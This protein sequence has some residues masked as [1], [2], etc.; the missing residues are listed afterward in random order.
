MPSVQT[1]SPSTVI[2]DLLDSPQVQRAFQFIDSHLDQIT[3]EQIRICS[4]PAPPFGEQ[5]RAGYLRQRFLEAGLADA[6]LDEEGNCLALR[7]GESPLR[8]VVVSAHL[9]TVFPADTNLRVT[10]GSDLIHGPGLGDNSLG[11]AALLGLFWAFRERGLQ[12]RGDVWLIANVCE[13]G[14]G[15]LR[16]KAV[17][18]TLLGI[19][20]DHAAGHNDPSLRGHTI[21][22]ALRH[23]P[24]RRLEHLRGSTAV[25][26][27]GS[28]QHRKLRAFRRRHGQILDPSLTL[29][30]RPRTSL[31]PAPIV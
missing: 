27:G 19:P 30:P 4:I 24:A 1:F 28:R 17:C 16:D 14:L 5:E 12:P 20:A 3:E 8:H 15:D 11:V 7:E 13:E 18:E 22:V 31:P 9:D 23:R 6:K 2:R 10:R 29:P 25:V 26:L 21:G